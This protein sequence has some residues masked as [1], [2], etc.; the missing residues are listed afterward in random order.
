MSFIVFP[1]QLFTP[2]PKTTQ[3]IYLIEEPIY[4]GDRKPKLNYNKIKLIWQIAAMRYYSDHLTK[5]KIKHT[6]IKYSDKVDYSKLPQPS[7]VYDP[8]DHQVTKKLPKTTIVLDTPNFFMSNADL[9]E[10]NKTFKS[11]YSHSKFYQQVKEKLGVLVNTKSYDQD[12][13]NKLPKDIKI[14]PLPSLTKTDQQY[15]YEAT[16]Y[17]NKTW[18]SALDPHEGQVIFPVTHASSKKWLDHFIKC[19]L[20]L[21]GKYQDAIDTTRMYLFHATISPMLNAGLLTPDQVLTAVTKAY[22]TKSL[23]IP[24]QSYEGFVRQ[25]I[26]WREYQRLLYKYEYETMVN[27]NY[28]NNKNKLS[29]PWYKGTLG[30]PPVDDAIKQAFKYGYI[31]HILRLMVMS[32]FMNLC[33]I[34]PD[35]VY[36]W[37]MEFSLD[38]YDWVMIQ[39]V[40]GMGMW[41]DAGLSMRKPYIST[42]AYILSMSNYKKGDWC[43]VW[44]SLYYLFLQQNEKQLKSTPYIRNLS[45][46]KKLSS[47]KQTELLTP[48]KKFIKEL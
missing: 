5:N 12:N 8:N 46:L 19:K 3:P 43:T 36:K 14:P 32:N 26:G 40:Y 45:Y 38:S 29:T 33:C 20:S 31:H 41:S 24:I 30:I 18:P 1:N 17:V 7:T 39:N 11:R 4:F 47:S 22:N 34:H 9:A 28:F 2:L 16:K 13:R 48:A 44:R 10:I 15:I 25:L 42:D 6:Y 35:Q 27:S 37:F 21:F 23:S